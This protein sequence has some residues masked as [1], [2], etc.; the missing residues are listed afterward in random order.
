MP[1]GPPKILEELAKALIPPACRE[2]VLGDLYERYKSPL[3]YLAD[4]LSTLPFVVLSRIIRT[5]DIRLLVMDALLVY[6]SFLAATWY[7]A[8]RLVTEEG[9]LMHLAIPSGLTLVGLLIGDAFTPPLK[10]P[11]SDWIKSFGIRLALIALCNLGGLATPANFYGLVTS[12]MLV[13]SAKLMF[14]PDAGQAQGAG[15][16]ALLA[17]QGSRPLPRTVRVS[18]TLVM[19][20][21]TC[22]IWWGIMSRNGVNP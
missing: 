21:V 13:S 14:G 12:L 18:V 3:Q 4:L 11:P 2:E 7:V 9:G 19:L 10:R 15:A 5:T 20:A 22:W 1:S 17:G 8:R 16:P 6:G